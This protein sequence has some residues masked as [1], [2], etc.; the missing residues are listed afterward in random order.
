MGDAPTARSVE[1]AAPDDFAQTAADVLI[2]EVLAAHEARGELGLCLAG[3][4]TPRAVYE[5]LVTTAESC[6]VGFPWHAV[7]V[8]FGDE[9]WVGPTD[10]ASNYRMACEA[11]ID[12][13]GIDDANVHRM[14]VGDAEPE[15][16]A[17]W[18]DDALPAQLDVLILGIGEDGHTASIFPDSKTLGERERRV[19]TARS[20]VPPHGRL[21]ITPA[22][23]EDACRVVVLATG[24]SKAGAVAAAIE[25]DIAVERCPARLARH[26]I[27]VLDTDAAA[28]LDPL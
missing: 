11:L 7:H 26:G 4:S 19:V 21:T 18:Y 24:A 23:I 2:R 9:R 16:V 25:G 27:W 17:A 1:V 12:P 3:G 10:P 14:R 6:V 28:G 22:V 5:R 20:P 15:V 8:W 13:A